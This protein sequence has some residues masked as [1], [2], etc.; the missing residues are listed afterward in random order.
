MSEWEYQQPRVSYGDDQPDSSSRLIRFELTAA[1]TRGGSAAAKPLRWNGSE[2]ELGSISLGSVYDVLANYKAP[3][4]TQGWCKWSGDSKHY[5]IVKLAMFGR[6][7][8]SSVGAVA[9]AATFT[10]D[11][12]SVLCGVDPRTDPTSS[13]E[14]VTVQN[15]LGEHSDDD[16][17]TWAEYDEETG[18]WHVYKF[19]S[20]CPP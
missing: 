8:G 3:S 5:E 14:T 18:L 10:I 13:S 12:I 1:L 15:D 19:N 11:G 7:K 6:I 2:V 17:A 4:G 20:I 16:A 9:G